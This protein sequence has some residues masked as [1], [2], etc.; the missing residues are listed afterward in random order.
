MQEV[1]IAKWVD[2]DSCETDTGERLRL[3]S[4]KMPDRGEPQ[5]HTAYRAA[6]Q[7]VPDGGKAEIRVVGR[8]CYGRK[9]VIMRTVDGKNVNARQIRRF[10]HR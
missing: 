1:T 2:G 10:E 8:D 6:Q 5:Y 9:I 3:A 4:A 7:L